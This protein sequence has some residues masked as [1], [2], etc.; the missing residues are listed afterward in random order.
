M[1]EIPVI[2]WGKPYESLEKVPVTHFETGEPLANVHQANGGIVKMDMRKAQKARDALRQI[3]IRELLKM[4]VKAGDLYATGT[5]DVGTG[6]QS[7][8]DFCRMQSASTGLPEA[9]C[10]ANMQKLAFVNKNIEQI[11][12][13]PT[14]GLPL[15]ILQT[16][17]GDEGRGVFV[18]YQATSPVM[19]LVL[20]SNSPGV[21]TLW[22]PAIPMQI[23]LVLK[24][25]SGDPWTP[26]R[27]AAAYA[28]AGIPLEA[29]SLYPGPH[30]VGGAITENCP[31]V[32]IFGGQATVDKYAGNPNVQVHGPGFSKILI[33]D[34]VVDR[35]EDYLDL[36]VDSI[37]LNSGRGCINCSGIWA[38][39]HTEEIADAI[40]QRL[41]K[42]EPKPMNDPT[43]NLAAFITPGVAEATNNQIE[44]N[45]KQPGV[46]EVTAKYRQGPRL[47]QRTGHDFLLPTIVHCSDPK[48]TLANPEYMFPMCS[49]VKCPQK[50]MIKTIGYTL[51]GTV[52]TENA[53][54]KSE[55]LDATNID[56][57]NLGQVRT[58]QMNWLQ[59]HEGNIIDFL[60]R[61]RAFQTSPPPAIA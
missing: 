61:S 13:A 45:L 20:P 21:H 50:D 32:M 55:L 33:G 11:L 28:A 58:V 24:P 48:A 7:P 25:G 1:L 29:I 38:S 37:F 22:L 52:L 18:S 5:L 59:P 42:V 2:R 23:G 15:D 46:T 51:V 16:G 54:W 17:Y 3:P 57:L 6:K 34:D 35:W 12:D 8:D 9:M 10:K 26:Y 19:G 43:A 40:A 30:E 41:A 36:M 44:D 4:C 47:I 53:A 14:R 60:F 56:R 31:R 27:M 49:V 39:R